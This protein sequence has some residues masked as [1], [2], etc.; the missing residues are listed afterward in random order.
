MTTL[1]ATLALL[2]I[3]FGPRPG[4]HTG[5]EAVRACPGVAASRCVQTTSWAA[6]IRWR[7]CGGCL[8]HKTIAALPAGGVALQ[9]TV[10]AERPLVARRAL[11]WPPIIRGRDVKAGF[12]GVPRRYGVYQLFARYGGVEAYVWAVFGRARPT[13]AQLARANG[14]LRTVRLRR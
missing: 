8:P 2:P 6:T 14:E 1:F 7:D 5:H 3:L 10:A 11:A 13:A 4:W 12:E 9:M